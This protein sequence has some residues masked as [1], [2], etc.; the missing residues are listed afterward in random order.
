MN[1]YE[2]ECEKIEEEFPNAKFTISIPYDEL[3]E[4]IT[5]EK[6]ILLKYR[7]NCYCNEN[8]KKKI[9]R[10]IVKGDCITNRLCINKL[11]DEGFDLGCNHHFL[12]GFNEN[13]DYEFEIFT[14]S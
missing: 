2:L 13:S 14:G 7:Y 9:E 6:E 4:I 10:F 11:I 3:D 1:Q 5:N 12:E 8:K